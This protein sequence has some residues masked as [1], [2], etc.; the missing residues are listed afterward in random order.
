MERDISQKQPQIVVSFLCACLNAITS[1]S[2]YLFSLYG[3]QLGKELGYKQVQLSF[4]GATGNNGLYLMGPFAGWLIDKYGTRWTC[5]AAAICLI[6]GY[7]SMAFTFNHTFPN[8]SFILMAIYYAFVGVGS[9]CSFFSAINVTAKNFTNLR[10]TGLSGPIAFFGLSAFILSQ[11]SK[12]FVDNDGKLDVY[13]FLL[14]MGIAFGIGNLIS[15]IWLRVIPSRELNRIYEEEE[16]VEETN[17]NEQTP[18][19]TPASAWSCIGD[20]SA[21]LL[22]SSFLCL[23]GT[24]LMVI[25]NIGTI[26]I[27]LLE[28]KSPSSI[29]AIKLQSFHVSLISI[30]SCFG[31][32]LSGVASDYYKIRHET[33]R[34]VFWIIAG[35][36]MLCSQLYTAF[37]L[38]LLGS[39]DKALSYLWILTVGTGYAYGAAFS[40]GPTITSESWGL[41]WFGMN[42]GVMSS[43]P[44]FGGLLMNLI[45]GFVYDFHVDEKRQCVGV[46]CFQAAFYVSSFI[47]FVSILLACILLVRTR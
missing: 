42:W 10:G 36:L 5:L 41:R 21:W 16:V 2:L 6:F 27:S 25:N 35:V 13:K 11:L 31:R 4:V 22:W 20:P 3:P 32:I 33:S 44:A 47:S 34:L 24:G 14:F 45:F 39:T 8:S 9:N 43:A 28:P 23:A 29:S 46:D 12:I 1:G 30:A 7:T 26:I 15:T 38:S 18:L 19:L 17:A 40:L 37:G